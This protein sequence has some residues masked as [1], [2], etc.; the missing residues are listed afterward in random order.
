LN[1]SCKVV[2]FEWFHMKTS[3]SSPMVPW[4]IF[5]CNVVPFKGFHTK[6]NMLGPLVH[7]LNSSAN[8]FEDPEEPL[9]RGPPVL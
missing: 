7:F 5:S 9:K 8:S 4:L 6:T 1:F 3:M 2:P